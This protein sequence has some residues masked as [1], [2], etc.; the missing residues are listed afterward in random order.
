MLHAR[1]EGVVIG[2]AEDVGANLENAVAELAHRRDHALG[3]VPRG[4]AAGDRRAVG[5][6]VRMRS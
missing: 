1:E 3:L 6:Q 4:D 5:G 2:P